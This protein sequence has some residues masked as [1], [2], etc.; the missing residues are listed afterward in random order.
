MI[1][2]RT[3]SWPDE[4][5]AYSEM[6]RSPSDAALNV[7]EAEQ[8]VVKPQSDDLDS[9]WLESASDDSHEIDLSPASSSAL[10]SR[11]KGSFRSGFDGR[12][13]EEEMRG[14]TS[15]RDGPEYSVGEAVND[16][17]AETTSGAVDGLAATDA[18]AEG[19]T[20]TESGGVTQPSSRN[21]T[22]KRMKERFIN[23]LIGIG[24]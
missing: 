17:V 24:I 11:I 15:K 22:N 9:G 2:L 21:P 4:S 13:E 7:N 6:V 19:V 20:E 5:V 16:G 8:V 1:V 23:G 12:A 10:A 18:A 14:G 3:D